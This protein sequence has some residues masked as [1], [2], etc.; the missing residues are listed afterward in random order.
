M[1]GRSEAVGLSRSSIRSRS[2]AV[3]VNWFS[4]RPTRFTGVCF[5]DFDV[6]YSRSLVSTPF[7]VHRI[8]PCLF[9]TVTAALKYSVPL[10][11]SFFLSS[12]VLSPSLVFP[13]S[14]LFPHV[15]SRCPP[16]PPLLLLLA[17]LRSR[18]SRRA[19]RLSARCC[20]TRSRFLACFYFASRL[21]VRCSPAFPVLQLARQK[22]IQ[23]KEHPASRAIYAVPFTE[24]QD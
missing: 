18:S 4:V 5:G 6:C 3:V 2:R 15:L 23:S 20:T 14:S 1:T 10:F 16:P 21:L 9:T 17:R 13:R 24:C 11:R 12:P 8:R 22:G 7:A 19:V